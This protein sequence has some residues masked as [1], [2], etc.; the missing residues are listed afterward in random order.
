[1][2]WDSELLKQRG[3]DFKMYKKSLE[4]ITIYLF[5]RQRAT[6]NVQEYKLMSAKDS[7]AHKWNTM[8][9]SEREK[10]R[11]RQFYKYWQEKKFYI[12]ILS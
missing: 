3:F 9:G 10:K 7:R 6:P 2:G 1:M 4:T 12:Y 5:A 8:Q 11:M